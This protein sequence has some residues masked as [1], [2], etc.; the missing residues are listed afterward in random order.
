MKREAN[1]Q[2]LD[3]WKTSGLSLRAF[4]MQEGVPYSRLLYW[5]KKLGKA[6]MPRDESS[7]VPIHLSAVPATNSPSLDSKTEVWLPNGI[8][9]DVGV[10]F[11]EQELRR[12]IGVLQTC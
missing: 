12:L 6:A 8:G 10:G 1:L 2:L 3:R 9:V 5:K 4:G 11:D 7:V